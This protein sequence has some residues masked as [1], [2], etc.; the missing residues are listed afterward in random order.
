MIQYIYP[1]ETK[2]FFGKKIKIKIKFLK[3][4]TWFRFNKI[5]ELKQEV[6][7]TEGPGYCWLNDKFWKQNMTNEEI[8]KSIWSWKAFS[9]DFLQFKQDQ[10]KSQKS[11]VASLLVAFFIVLISAQALGFANSVY[12]E[13][14]LLEKYK[15][16][17]VIVYSNKG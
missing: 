7:T 11:I 2:Y 10:Q 17:N 4:V 5:L 6:K 16:I 9:Q 13:K 12:N 3:L 14:V 1:K 8:K 15:N